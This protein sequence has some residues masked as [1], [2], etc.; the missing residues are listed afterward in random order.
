MLKAF[1]QTGIYLLLVVCGL[2]GV[3][4]AA[5]VPFFE[6]PDAGSHFKYIA[7][8]QEQRRLPVLEEAAARFSHE[9]VQQ[10]PFYYA[11]AALV[12]IGQPLGEA[13]KLELPNPYGEKGLSQRATVSLPPS[14]WWATLPL[15]TARLV[16]LVGFL[17]TIWATW[18]L[19]RTLAPTQPWLALTT[20]SV[21]G[22]NPQFLFSAASITNDTWV[23]AAFCLAVWRAAVARRRPLE[24]RQWFFVG[25]WVGIAALT[26]YS[27][28]LAAAPVGLL[29]IG[30][31]HRRVLQLMVR[32]AFWLMVGFGVT[33]GFWYAR[34][35]LLYGELTPLSTILRL[36]PGLARPQSLDWL[37]EDLWREAAW[38]LRSYWGVYGYGIIAPASYHGV[39]QNLLLLAGCGLLILWGRWA[40]RQRF[41]QADLLLVAALWLGVVLLSLLNWMRLMLFTNQGRLLFPAAP[42]VAILLV[43]GWQSWAPRRWHPCLHI[44]LPLLWLGLAVSQLSVL[45]NSYRLPSALPSPVQPDRSLNARFAGGMVVMG[46]DLP[47]GAAISPERA[48]PLTVYFA[49]TEP[50]LDFYTLFIHLADGENRLLYQFDGVPAQGR[51]ATRQWRVGE[52]FAD[53]YWLTVADGIKPGLATLSL[54]FYPYRDPTQRQT[55]L[56][57]NGNPLGDRLL[58]A[59]VRVHGADEPTPSLRRPLARWQNGIELRTAQVVWL[60][61]NVPLAVAVEWQAAAVIHTDYTVFVQVLDETGQLVAQVDQRPQE[62]AYP[63]STWR[64]GDVIADHYRF[65]TAPPRW[66]RIILGLYDAQG[67]RLARQS[68]QEPKD[69]YVVLEREP[70]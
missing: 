13:L 1:P 9:L 16:V 17:L 55:V 15:H 38:L 48:L 27:G 8:L 22:L 6:G 28:L 14:S 45:Y 63:T 59:P 33:A 42:A 29:W 5:V 37:G 49:A 56:D 11:L 68:E 19:V 44:A 36:L 26:K 4:Y 50:I 47:E 41:E 32:Q 65:V 58:L 30:Q 21:V 23:A 43:I 53:T 12:S 51:H 57:A 10:P 3:A 35:L 67:K 20:A 18:A 61:T 31:E 24:M 70:S 25:L 64:R 39:I 2:V 46:I 7:Y 52:V 34:N 40:W 62:G 69:F 60:G 54:G 66:Q